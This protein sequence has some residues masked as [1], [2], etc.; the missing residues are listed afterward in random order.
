M[1]RCDYLFLPSERNQVSSLI[2][3][4]D[5]FDSQYWKLN[6]VKNRSVWQSD[7]RDIEKLVVEF[8]L[9]CHQEKLSV[10]I[11]QDNLLNDFWQKFLS[12]GSV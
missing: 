5:W 2:C 6:F 8:C 4:T 11:V 9:F 1:L 7:C 10:L 3:D 12:E